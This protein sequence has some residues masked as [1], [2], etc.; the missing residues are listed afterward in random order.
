MVDKSL[1]Q[2]EPQ[3]DGSVRYRMLE[4]LREYATEQLHR[5]G[6]ADEVQRRHALSFADIIVRRWG[7]FWFG[8][9]TE[10]R[11]ANIARATMR[12]SGKVCAGW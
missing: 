1:I 6:K 8:E 7:P 2:T 11:L 9:N 4:T 3:P 10:R 12:T 5:S